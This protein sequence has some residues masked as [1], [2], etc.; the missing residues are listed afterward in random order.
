MSSWAAAV[1]NDIA[2]I[3]QLVNGGENVNCRDP[4]TAETALMA[5]ATN[6]S[7]DSVKFLLTR[8]ADPKIRNAKGETALDMVRAREAAF[9]KIPNMAAV[10]QRQRQVIALLAPLAV[11]PQTPAAPVTV[12]PTDMDTVARLKLDAAKVALTA[13]QYDSAGQGVLDV[14][15][16]S[17]VSERRRA[18]AC[19]NRVRPRHADA[20]LGTGKDDVRQGPRV[21]RRPRRRPCLGDGDANG[22]SQADARTVQMTP[23]RA[24]RDAHRKTWAKNRH[25]MR[26][27]PPSRRHGCRGGHLD[28][29]EPLAESVRAAGALSTAVT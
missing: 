6:G 14:I 7:V 16:M 21:R 20:R 13:R 2:A 19:T 11:G 22:P 5:G 27:S 25:R 23:R 15:Q 9:S 1:S 12:V 17:G 4:L 10:V 26:S 18:Q 28:F 8:G 29:V 24:V 3:T